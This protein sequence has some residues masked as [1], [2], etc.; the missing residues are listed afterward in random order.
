M[1]K[2]ND[3]YGTK[4]AKLE[5]LVE[6]LESDN[7]ELDKMISSVEEGLELA[8]SLKKELDQAENKIQKLKQKYQLD[9]N[10]D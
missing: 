3:N 2:K 9:N 7:L 6:D 1:A 5:K 4:L 8:D 10:A